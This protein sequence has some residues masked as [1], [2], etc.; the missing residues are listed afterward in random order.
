MKPPELVVRVAVPALLAPNSA[1]T[2]L[3]VIEVRFEVLALT[4]W[5]VALLVTSPVIEV[6][7]PARP[8]CSAPREIVVPPV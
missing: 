1:V 5:N 7:V 4:I 3:V 6:A 2:P 8:S